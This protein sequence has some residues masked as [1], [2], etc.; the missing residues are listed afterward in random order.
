MR[1]RHLSVKQIVAELRRQGHSVEVY[2]R[3][4][5]LRI[6]RIDGQLFRPSGS[7]GNIAGRRLVGARLTIGQLR[8]I[9]KQ[10]RIVKEKQIR[11]RKRKLTKRQKEELA[12]IN[13]VAR[14]LGI[15]ETPEDFAGKAKEERGGNWR[16]LARD[17]RR[18][19]KAALDKFGIRPDSAKGAAALIEE[20]ASPELLPSRD[21]LLENSEYIDYLSIQDIYDNIY[22]FIHGKISDA[23]ANGNIKAIIGVAKENIK[24]F[25]KERGLRPQDVGI[26][27]RKLD[28]FAG[29]FDI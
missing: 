29:E 8:G 25:L 24:Q 20:K 26:S 7:A 1:N 28:D 18:R 3:R 17:L 6:T 23:V 15:P 5:G 19:N 12:R 10:R 21:L 2:D 16:K 27:E 13:K 14:K 9:R 11:A 22:D 4:D